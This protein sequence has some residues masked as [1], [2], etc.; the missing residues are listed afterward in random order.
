MANIWTI[1]KNT[2]AQI[3]RMKIAL[4]VILLLAVLLPLL[5]V[6]IVG[7][8]TLIGKLQTFSS[9]G[10]SLT[11]LLLCILTI[12]IS[13][14]M[15]NSDFK[16]KVVYTILT[17]PV[18]RYQYLLGKFFGILVVNFILLTVFS[19][20]IFAFTI[21]LPRFT[22]AT[23]KEIKQADNEFFTSRISIATHID[24]EKIKSQAK[25]KLKKL[26]ESNAPILEGKSH[27]SV[28]NTLC[29]SIAMKERSV[30]P[31]AVKKWSFENV[32]PDDLS[33]PL[34]IRFTFKTLN[35]TPDNSVYTRWLIG[36]LSDMDSGKLPDTPIYDSNLRKDVVDTVREF[37]VPADIIAKDGHLDI[38]MQNMYYNGTTIIADK[39]ELL[40]KSDSFA[41]NF[42]RGVALIFIRLIF[43]TSLGVSLST[44]LSFPVAIMVALVIYA[45]GSING[46]IL[47][48]FS[49]LSHTTAVYYALLVKPIIFMLPKFDGIYN[50]TPMIVDGKTITWLFLGSSF[51]FTAF[52]KSSLIFLYGIFVFKNREIARITL[53]N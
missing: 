38:A 43:L 39:V 3:F 29:G 8:G 5:S 22:K 13:C 32:V 9:Y 18:L 46:F 42:F 14:Y 35:D 44:W 45:T 36:D 19:V 23:D 15:L 6:V 4:V 26:I 49:Y 17:K 16:D 28:F 11:S 51:F 30:E 34:Y 24:R 27:N 50:P 53:H 40:Y 2:I 33:K 52:V 31:G 1:A 25:E 37:Q 48:S 10:L 12:A 20:M 47:D 7:D 41:L 21:Y